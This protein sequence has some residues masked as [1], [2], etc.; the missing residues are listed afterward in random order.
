M[1]NFSQNLVP[2]EKDVIVKKKNVIDN[3][4]ANENRM[5]RESLI[6]DLKKKQGVLYEPSQNKEGRVNTNNNNSSRSI[7]KNRNRK[8]Q[9]D[10]SNVT[11]KEVL[12]FWHK[13]DDFD[14]EYLND[15]ELEIAELEF[16]E[17]I[18]PEEKEIKLRMLRVYNAEI[19]EREKRKK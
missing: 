6:E 8:D 1:N 13:R 3:K 15:A 7:I 14:I 4:K 5:K 12:G 19:E 11:S 18:S 10:N 9:K 2:S 17:D 16:P